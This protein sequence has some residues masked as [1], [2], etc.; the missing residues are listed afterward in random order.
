MRSSRSIKPARRGDRDFDAAPQRAELALHRRAAVERGDANADFLAERR[1]HVDDLL[2]ELTGGHQH[3]RSRVP[4]AGLLDPLQHRKSEG[5]GLARAGLG[6]AA[7]VVAGEGI[8]D[9]CLLDGEG[10]LD[11]LSSQG[12]DQLG[13]KAE[14]GERRHAVFLSVPSIVWLAPGSV[15]PRRRSESEAEQRLSEAASRDIPVLDITRLHDI[16]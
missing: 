8:L 12:V 16:R 14:F 10:V 13:P 15:A 1:Q 11:A 4:R 2:G 7:Y 5:E 6:L 3:Q 9:G